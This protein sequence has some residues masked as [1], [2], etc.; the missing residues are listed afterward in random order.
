M[1]WTADAR[2]K[3]FL[4]NGY[5]VGDAKSAKRAQQIIQEPALTFV[6]KTRPTVEECFKSLI[7]E[8]S[9]CR[10]LNRQFGGI[11]RINDALEYCHYLL[12]RWQCAVGRRFR[13]SSILA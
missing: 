1:L 11:K 13:V 8:K 12:T 3:L 10:A 7:R 5:G 9:D 2:L 6:D 4:R